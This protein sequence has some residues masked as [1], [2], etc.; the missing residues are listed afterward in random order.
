MMPYSRAGRVA[1]T[2]SKIA[3]LLNTAYLRQPKGQIHWTVRA[4]T[5]EAGA[6]K[7]PVQP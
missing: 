6:S 2:T 4:L 1:M 3:E 5:D 7:S